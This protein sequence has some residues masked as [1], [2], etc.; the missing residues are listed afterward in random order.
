MR[1]IEG[2]ENYYIICGYGV[3][4]N[5]LIYIK[6]GRYTDK[7]DFVEAVGDEY[8]YYPLAVPQTVQLTPTAITALLGSNTVWSDTNGSNTAV[9]VKK[10]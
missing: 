9:Y 7:D 1:A 8:I 5:G 6:D 4:R 10:G 2:M 3:G